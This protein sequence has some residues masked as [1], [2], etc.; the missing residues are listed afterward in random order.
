M[1]DNKNNI[2]IILKA[3]EAKDLLPGDLNG[4]SDPYFKIP[5]GQK[6]VVDLPKKQHRT[7]TI[8][9]TLNP[10]WNESFVIEYNPMIC[11][12]LRI[13]VYDY[14]LIGRNDFLG[15]GYATLEWINGSENYNEEWIPLSIEKENKATKK[16][17]LIQKGS[18]HIKI[19]V[20]GFLNLADDEEKPFKINNMMPQEISKSIVVHK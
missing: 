18:V 14:D 4:L 3:I 13:E 9:N 1:E 8:D 19:R 6:G 16:K 2:K 5:H 17:E 15:G 20:L 11:T 10:V 12:K 7:K